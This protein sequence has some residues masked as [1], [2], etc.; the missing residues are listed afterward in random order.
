MELIRQNLL[1]RIKRFFT[2]LSQHNLFMLSASISYY[3]AVA[4]APFLVIVLSAAAY[5]GG[6]LQ[7]KLIVQ[8]ANFSPELGQM[9]KIIF[10]N[11][12]EGIDVGSITG[13]IGLF[14]LFITASLFFLQLRFALDVIYGFHEIRG[15]KS[16]W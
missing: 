5:L 9:V 8:A 6:N 4:I 15:K 16:V 3:S 11:I 10:A 14:I 12:N 2:G 13:L 7:Q 1:K